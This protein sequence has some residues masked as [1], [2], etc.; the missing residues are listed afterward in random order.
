MCKL[1]TAVLGVSMI[2][3]S[4][5]AA[6]SDLMDRV[7]HGYADSDGVKIHYAEIGSGPPVVF[8][9][10]FP[11]FW[12]SWRHQMEALA[13][14]GFRAVA[15]DQRGYNLSDKPEGV[16]AYAMPNLVG[17]VVAVIRS[18]GVEKATVV[19]HDWGGAV[20]WQVALNVPQVVDKLIILNLPHPNGMTR[21][22][23]TNPEQQKNSEYARSFQTK[24]ASDPDVFFG[25]PL[26]PQM[27]AGWVTDP[28]A[29]KH[30][31]EAFEQTDLEATLNYYKANYPRPPYD[32]AWKRIQ[33]SPGPKVQMPVLQFHGLNDT[34]LNAHGL[35]DTWE[36]LEKDLTL[37][38]VP[39]AGH[40]VQQ[41]APELVSETMVWWLKMR[42]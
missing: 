42:K 19:G 18:L 20:A 31:V 23:A 1:A 38:T 41:D 40:F 26:Q 34:A 36:W 4:A 16:A 10:G 7:K 33:E 2:A 5:S 27:M 30:Y 25:M 29:K 21:E 14:A 37:V 32:E 39:G 9:H 15:I 17:D 3:A 8:I 11:D 13:E 28:E 6:D 22:L 24:S 35:N 12:Y